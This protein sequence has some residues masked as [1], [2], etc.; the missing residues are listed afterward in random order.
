MVI[1]KVEVELQ[2]RCYEDGQ[3]SWKFCG[4]SECAV[5]RPGKYDDAPL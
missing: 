1:D 4:D 2:S 5:M 3:V